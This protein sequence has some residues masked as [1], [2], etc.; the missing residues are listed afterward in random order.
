[1]IHALAEAPS[2]LLK[3]RQ[4]LARALGWQLAILVLD[5]ATMWLMFRAIGH[6]VEIWIAFVGFAVA[7]ALAIVGPMPLGPFEAG[8]VGMLTALSNDLGYAD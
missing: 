5:V 7:A 8:S 1:M 2:E 6:P 3:N 4:L